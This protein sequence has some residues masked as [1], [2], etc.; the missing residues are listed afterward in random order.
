MRGATS[1]FVKLFIVNNA[2]WNDAFQ[3]GDCDDTSWNFNGQNFRMDVKATKTGPALLTLSTDNGFIV[4]ADP[5]KRVLYFSCPDTSIASVL[6]PGPFSDED[7][8]DRWAEDNEPKRP[9]GEYVYDLI[10]YDNN[11]PPTRVELMNG[12]VRVGQGVTGN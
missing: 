9:P 4:I 7:E 8:W 1:A 3:F 2:T 10:M 12:T 11:S 5:I 6:Q